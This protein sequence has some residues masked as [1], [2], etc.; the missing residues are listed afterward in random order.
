VK[1]I[2]SICVFWALEIKEEKNINVK[3]RY[4]K[5]LKP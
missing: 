5:N 4:L 2:S 3:K 1:S